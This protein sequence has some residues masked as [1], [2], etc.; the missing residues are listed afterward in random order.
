MKHFS[1][2]TSDLFGIFMCCGYIIYGI[3]V[4]RASMVITQAVIVRPCVHGRAEILEVWSP[5][6]VFSWWF[7]RLLVGYQK[8]YFVW[9]MVEIE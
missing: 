6:G 7:E 3:T 9:H 4:T 5:Y 1:I 2:N 8:E